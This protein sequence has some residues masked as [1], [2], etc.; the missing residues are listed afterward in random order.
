MIEIF[1]KLFEDVLRKDL[2][3]KEWDVKLFA[4]ITGVNGRIIQG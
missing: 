4:S 2:N 3:G 1:D